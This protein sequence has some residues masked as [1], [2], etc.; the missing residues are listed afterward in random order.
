LTT[1]GAYSLSVAGLSDAYGNPLTPFTDNFNIVPGYA[2]TATTFQNVDIFGQAG[3]Q[4]LTFSGGQVTADDDFGTINLGS[5]SFTF[6]S[7]TYDHLYVSSNGLITFGSGNAAYVPTN[8]TTGPAQ[9]AIAAYW[10]DLIKTGTEPMIVWQINNNKLYV[11]WYNVTNYPAGTPP[12]MTFLAILDLN[13]GAAAPGDIVLNYN[14]VTGV[15]A[16]DV[17]GGIT[18]GVKDAGTG[19]AV[20][21]TTVQ[22]GSGGGHGS[23]LIQT[24][25]A[26]LI[27]A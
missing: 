17:S 5:N 26:I 25:H 16:S 4:T 23:P 27:S 21:H 15:G 7:Q 24:G 2:A 1:T 22:D 10:T 18:V 12:A 6:Y 19:A 3:T 13:T 8:L 9:A 14:S 11:E 20:T